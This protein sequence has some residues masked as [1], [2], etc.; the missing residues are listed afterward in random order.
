ME[1]RT[2]R[3]LT[4]MRLHPDERL[5]LPEGATVLNSWLEPAASDHG[6]GSTVVELTAVEPNADAAW[7]SRWQVGPAK[8]G[9]VGAGNGRGE[10]EDT[11]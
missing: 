8:I 4:V 11:T 5:S 7:N 1:D 9:T 6:A 2:S 10:R 3:Q